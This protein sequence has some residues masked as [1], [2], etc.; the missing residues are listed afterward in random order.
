MASQNQ[1]D[2]A[3]PAGER[4]ADKAYWAV[5]ER[6]FDG[7]LPAGAAVP[8]RRLSEDIGL[9]RSRLREALSRLEGEGVLTR[10]RAHVLCVRDVT[11]NDALFAL[12]LLQSFQPALAVAAA[13]PETLAELVAIEAAI[14]AVSPY[15]SVAETGFLRAAMALRRIQADDCGN[16]FAAPVARLLWQSVAIYQVASGHQARAE[17]IASALNLCRALRGVSADSPE[18]AAIAHVTEVRTALL[19]AV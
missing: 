15:G 9:S 18:T 11:L 12:Q 5:L 2:V 17:E 1:S 4:L 8:E 6:V 10:D 14:E 7:V 13:S 16:P 3:A 19:A